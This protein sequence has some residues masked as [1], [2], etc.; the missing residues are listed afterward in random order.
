MFGLALRSY[1]R[2][3]QRITEESEPDATLWQS[4]LECLETEGPLARSRLVERYSG[5]ETVVVNAVLSDLVGSGLV[6]RSGRGEGASFALVP[7]A[8]LSKLAAESSAQALEGFVWLTIFRQPSMTRA[9]LAL[10]FPDAAAREGALQALVADGRVRMTRTADGEVLEAGPCFVPV[11]ATLGWEAAVFDHFQAVTASIIEKLRRS[12]PGSDASDE[13]GGTTVHFGI[14]LGHPHSEEVRGTLADTRRRL[15]ALLRK[16]TEHNRAQPIAEEERTKVTF[17][18]G[19]NVIEP[20]RDGN[21]VSG[22]NA[23]DEL[24]SMK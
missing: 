15:D 3:I 10:R 21:E 16:V 9:E 6:Y 14:H 7:D 2:K 4:I 12:G 17:Y 23:Q 8:D 5:K 22:A 18:F 20:A 11:G 24:E 19:Q 13:I 1:Q